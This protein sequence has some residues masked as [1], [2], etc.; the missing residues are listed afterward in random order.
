[1]RNQQAYLA[2]LHH[3]QQQ[4]YL[5]AQQRRGQ[6]SLAQAQHKAHLARL[7]HQQDAVEMEST[8]RKVDSWIMHN[9]AYDEPQL[10]HNVLYATFPAPAPPMIPD[11]EPLVFYSTPF[12]SA[13]SPSIPSAH[14]SSPSLSSSCTTSSSASFPNTPITASSFSSIPNAIIPNSLNNYPYAHGPVSFY[15]SA[16][17]VPPAGGGKKNGGGGTHVSRGSGGS[18]SLSDSSNPRTRH[19]SLSSIP[20]EV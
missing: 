1:M 14:S 19:S 20:E 11:S 16:D 18:G 13:S 7:Q 4:Q 12:P 9:Q 8:R 17:S 10:H 15:D 3:Q 2:Q 5:V 6:A